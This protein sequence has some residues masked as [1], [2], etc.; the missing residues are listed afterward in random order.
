MTT[1]AS[2]TETGDGAEEWA[3]G[4]QVWNGTTPDLIERAITKSRIAA[5]R[6]IGD[7][8]PSADT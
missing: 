5:C 3:S 1:P 4:T 8:P 6:L 7:L 2:T